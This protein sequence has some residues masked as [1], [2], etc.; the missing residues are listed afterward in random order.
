[1]AAQLFGGDVDLVAT[2]LWSARRVCCLTGAG[3]S[4]ES[5]VPTFRGQGG[6]WAGRRVEEIATPEAFVRDPA[7]VWKF[8][9]WRRRELAQTG[10]NAGHF[11]LADIEQ[12]VTDFTLITQNV[13][14]LHGRAGS[15][16]VVELHGNL[17]VN[18]CPQCGAE[19][20][21]AVTELHKQIPVCDSC[22]ATMRPGV[23][24]FGEMLPGD[25]FRAATRAAS[26]CDVM[27]VVGTSSVVQ[28]AASLA[29][30]AWATGSML[31]EINPDRTGLS[32]SADVRFPLAAGKVLPEIAK[33]LR[34]RIRVA[35]ATR[36]VD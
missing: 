22:G 18:H 19:D 32:P 17:W 10:P 29:G 25:Q 16:N 30:E 6:F 34:E 31:V 33:A 9:L 27:M 5:G 21:C 14:D 20:R 8:Y 2:R 7:G 28:P 12:L 13:D 36:S 15:R 35:N 4:A 11:A 1:M 26:T 3:I 24:W 23:V